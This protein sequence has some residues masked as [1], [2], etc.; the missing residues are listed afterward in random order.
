[1][2]R[3]KLTIEYQGTDY[4]GWQRQPDLPT[5]QSEIEK[6]I[7]AFCGQSV[8]VTSAGRTDAGVHA[9]GQIAHVDLDEF[10]KPM[11]GYAISKAINAHLR[12]QPIAVINTEI[13]EDDFHA[14]FTAK[15]KL[16]AY[17]IISR[18]AF[19]TFDQNRA[20]HIK[21]PLDVAAMHEAAQLLLGQHDFSTFRDSEC[22]A[23][24]PVRTLDRLDVQSFQTAEGAQEIFIE[25]EAMSFLHHMVRNIV[26]TLTLVG[27]G[28]WKPEDILTALN[29]K[30]RTKGG[31]TAPADGLYLVRIDYPSMT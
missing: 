1:M 25:A 18:Q 16:Y 24:N 2:T 10:S 29:A 7:H 30:D 8:E 26:G 13:V 28:K 14:R 15:N 19:L 5:I 6:A 12:P 3:Y 11:D 4:Y 20:W 31:P 17:R 27:E 22:Q 9:R 21:R 23:K